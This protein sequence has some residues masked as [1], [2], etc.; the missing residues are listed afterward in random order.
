[1]WI[2]WLFSLVHSFLLINQIWNNQKLHVD[3]NFN[4]SN[5]WINIFMDFNLQV[6]DFFLSSLFQQIDFYNVDVVYRYMKSVIMSCLFFFSVRRFSYFF[7]LFNFGQRKKIIK[8]SFSW[9]KTTRKRR[10][11]L[12]KV[13]CLAEQQARR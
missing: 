5:L 6:I 10:C 13:S 7:P 1:V 2:I 9:V 11:G 12:L 4:W 8:K 3:W